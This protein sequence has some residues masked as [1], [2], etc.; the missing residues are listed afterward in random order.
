MYEYRV[1]VSVPKDCAASA[2]FPSHSYRAML[3]SFSSIS[4]WSISS[5]SARHNSPSQWTHVLCH[6]NTE[7]YPCMNIHTFPGILFLECM[8]CYRHGNI[9]LW[10]SFLICYCY[11]CSVLLCWFT[12]VAKMPTPSSTQNSVFLRLQSLLGLW[13]P[14]NPIMSLKGWQTKDEA[15]G[16]YSF[17][18]LALTIC[19]LW[20]IFSLCLSDEAILSSSW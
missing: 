9:H 6:S 16:A 2:K 17:G 15:P 1:S 7:W 13:L 3:I 19:G 10:R 20:M 14:W 18:T 12:K 5:T 4:A 11:L 8:V